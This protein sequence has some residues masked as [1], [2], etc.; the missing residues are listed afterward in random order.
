VLHNLEGSPLSASIWLPLN[1]YIAHTTNLPLSLEPSNILFS[2]N[3]TFPRL[4][5]HAQYVDQSM[6]RIH[7]QY[8]DQLIIRKTCYAKRS[9]KAKQ[10]TAPDEMELHNPMPA[11]HGQPS[12]W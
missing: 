6:H 10:H 7:A 3:F 12:K 5:I 2:S 4:R 11:D 1:R 8:V 9:L